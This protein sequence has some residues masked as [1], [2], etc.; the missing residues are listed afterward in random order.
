M[1]RIVATLSLALVAFA[2]TALLASDAEAKRLGGGSSSGMKRDS[3]FMK[4]DAT[5]AAPAQNAA[6]AAKP[7]TPATPPAAQPS[8]MS[9]WLGPIAGIAAGLGI[10]ALLSHFGLGEGMANMLMILLAVAA[11]VFVVKLLLRKRQENSGMQYAGAGNDA[12]RVEPSHFE[13]ASVANVGAGGTAAM[14][15]TSNIPADFDVEG[16]LRQAKLNYIRLQAANDRGDMDDIRNFTSPEMF[17]EIQMQYEERGRAKQETDV[18]QL[19]AT[20]LDVSEEAGRH[21][22]SVRFFGHIREAADAMPEALDEVWHLSKP[23]SGNGG[24]V[25]AGIQQFQ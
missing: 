16:F 24:W 23:V 13:P 12:G 22:V 17:A 10:A 15:A 25:I 1:K 9:R 18:Q 2:G 14:T 8:G 7:A 11:V 21:V 20:L 5:P 6:S 3:T 19:E 4:R